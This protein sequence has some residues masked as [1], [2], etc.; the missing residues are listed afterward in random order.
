MK[1][2]L[3]YNKIVLVVQ[4][5]VLMVICTQNTGVKCIL[6]ILLSCCELFL[7]NYPPHVVAATKWPTIIFFKSMFYKIKGNKESLVLIYEKLIFNII[8]TKQKIHYISCNLPLDAAMP[9]AQILVGPFCLGATATLY[10][11]LVT[12]GHRV[13]KWNRKQTKLTTKL[14]QNHSGL[15]LLGSQSTPEKG[16]LNQC[17]EMGEIAG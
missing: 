16:K 6:Q 13:A 3:S 15:C 2:N 14:C 10:F 12:G 9:V 7:R 17:Q 11:S 1:T 8:I 5:V 4:V